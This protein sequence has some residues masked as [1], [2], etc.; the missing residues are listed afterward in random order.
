MKFPT[1]IPTAVT[2]KEAAKLADLAY[3]GTVLELGAHFGFSTIVMADVANRVHSVDWHQGDPHAG[4]GNSLA[5]FLDNLDSYGVRSRVT[6]HM[7]RFEHVLPT[8]RT[9]YFDGCFFDGSHDYDSIVEDID[10]AY[11]LV[12]PGG[13]LAFHDYG[14]FDVSRALENTISVPLTVIDSLAV[15]NKS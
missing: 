6:V 12:R 3:G 11:R 14:R 5:T 2:S 7:G 4:L 10:L 1:D 13:W 9:G 15:C 8:M